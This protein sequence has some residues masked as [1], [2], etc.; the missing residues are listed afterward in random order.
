MVLLVSSDFDRLEKNRDT[1]AEVDDKF[2]CKI[3]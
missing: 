1:E 2:E 3:H